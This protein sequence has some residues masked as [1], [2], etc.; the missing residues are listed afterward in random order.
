MPNEQEQRRL[1]L[2]QFTRQ[3]VPFSQLPA[4]SNDESNRL[5]IDVAGIGPD[6]TVLDVACG[7]GLVAC[8]L[9]EV[10]KHVT[11]VDITPAMIEQAKSRQQE[12]ELTNLT[13][14]VG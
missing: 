11:G 10:A 1:I 6:D 2:D 5:L 8:S 12:K 9:S 3:A 13:W 7:P 4:Q 14:V